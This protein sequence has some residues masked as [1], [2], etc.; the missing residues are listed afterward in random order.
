MFFGD[1]VV[2]LYLMLVIESGL[3]SLYDAAML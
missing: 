1:G 3:C 2:R